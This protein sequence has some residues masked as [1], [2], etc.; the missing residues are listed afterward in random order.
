VAA[1]GA[2]VGAAASARAEKVNGV[3]QSGPDRSLDRTIGQMLIIG[4]RGADLNSPSVKAVSDWLK[5]GSIGGVIFFE[6]NLPSPELAKRLLAQFRRAAAPAVPLLC[7]DQEGGSVAR[8]APEH[9]FEPLASAKSIASA[10]LG[11]AELAY[12]HTARELHTLGF[13]VNFGPVVDLDLNAI[14]PTIEELGRSYGADPTIV[15]EFAKA[16]IDAHRRNHIA[17]ALKHFPG[18][19]ST[20]DD[21]HLTLPNITS[22]WRKEELNPFA[23]L[24]TSGYADMVM[25]G[26]LVHDHMTGGRPASLSSRAIQGLLRGAMG[27]DGVVVSDDMQMSALRNYYPPDE[28]I[29]LGIEAGIDLFIYSNREHADPSMPG[30]FHRVVRGALESGRI[31]RARIDKSV[32]RL[33]LLRSSVMLAENAASN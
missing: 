23:Q 20:A 31:A 3:F 22:V 1:F 10:S 14:N 28:S 7:V 18:H 19:G 16:F 26:H 2:L 27:Y 12:D 9:G 32:K 6:D 30:R 21:S 29:L 8:L 13:N 17:T 11:D 24:I 15:V 25:V 4:F 5:D 33:E